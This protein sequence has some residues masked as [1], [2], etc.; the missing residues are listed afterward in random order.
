LKEF[1]DIDPTLTAFNTGNPRLILSQ[2][3]GTV[4]LTQLGILPFADKKPD[5]RAM[6]L[7]SYGSHSMNGPYSNKISKNQVVNPLGKK[8]LPISGKSGSHIQKINI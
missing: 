6:V 5:Q 3:L 7:G 1:N 4:A 8:I 2:P